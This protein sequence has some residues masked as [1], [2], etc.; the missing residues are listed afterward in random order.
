MRV[1]YSERKKQDKKK[2]NGPLSVILL[3]FALITLTAIVFLVEVKENKQIQNSYNEEYVSVFKE[4]EMY[5]L[6][7]FEEI[8]KE[9]AS[10]KNES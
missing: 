7:G 1:L 4:S 6:L 9:R 3:T 2:E 10:D 8:E 5:E